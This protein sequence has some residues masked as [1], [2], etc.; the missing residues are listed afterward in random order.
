MPT[1]LPPSS[2][3]DDIDELLYLARVGDTQAFQTLLTAV[4]KTHHTSPPNLLPSVQDAE[5]GNTVLHMAAANGQLGTH[6]HA[7]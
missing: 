6:T 5:T 1:A 2:S 7:Q 4:S 3:E